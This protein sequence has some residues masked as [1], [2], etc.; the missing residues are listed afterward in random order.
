MVVIEIVVKFVYIFCLVFVR[1][2]DVFI[3]F[4]F[5]GFF[6]EIVLVYVVKCIYLIEIG[7]IVLIICI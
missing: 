6:S 7:S 4:K 1:I 2:R 5:I 3:N